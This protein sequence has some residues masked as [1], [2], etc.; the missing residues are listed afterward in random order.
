MPH[1]PS[2]ALRLVDPDTG[3][4][5]GE[6]CPNCERLADQLAGAENNVRSMRAQMANL[7]RELAGELDEEAKEFPAAVAL[8][9]YWQERCNH[10]RA[11]F[12]ADRM[13]ALLP[14]AEAP[15]SS[16]LPRGDPR[17]SL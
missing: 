4:P 9:R 8:F 1:E 6:L 13:K 12:T 2:H 17:R 3:E 16:C 15:R 11:T 5:T 7:K 14:T 10:P